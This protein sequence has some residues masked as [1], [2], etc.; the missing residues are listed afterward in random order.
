MS[1]RSANYL[2]EKKGLS[3]WL[4]TLD[5]KRIGILYMIAVFSFFLSRRGVCPF[6]SF[7]AF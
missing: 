7:R 1:T 6:A 4:F 3:S 5:H 2:N